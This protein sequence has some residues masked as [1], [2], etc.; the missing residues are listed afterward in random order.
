MAG[1][2]RK[3]ANIRSFFYCYASRVKQNLC[4]VK[5]ISV[6]KPDFLAFFYCEACFP[7]AWALVPL[8][9]ASM[10]IFK[11]M[12][13]LAKYVFRASTSAGMV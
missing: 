5:R 9:E 8:P 11:G 3:I 4:I 6:I 2:C 12:F 1:P 7:M 13:Y 10:A